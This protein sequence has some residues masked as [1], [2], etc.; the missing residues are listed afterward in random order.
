MEGSGSGSSGSSS[1]SSN[2][3]SRIVVD[4]D[5]TTGGSEYDYE[6]TVTKRNS[7]SALTLSEALD[8][9][10]DY[11]D[12]E[13]LT[14]VERDIVSGSYV[15]TVEDSYGFHYTYVYTFNASAN[16]VTIYV[17]GDAVDVA[18]GTTLGDLAEEC[19]KWM[20]VDGEYEDISDS[21]VEVTRGTRYTI[22]SKV[23]LDVGTDGNGTELYGEVG[24]AVDMTE[25]AGN[26]YKLDGEE[27]YLSVEDDAITFTAADQTV[28]DGYVY[29]KVYFNTG[30]PDTDSTTYVKAGT[31]YSTASGTGTGYIYSVGD[32]DFAYVANDGSI[33]ASDDVVI[34]KG[35]VAVT[36]TQTSGES[37][38]YSW[39]INSSDGYALA[40]DTLTVEYTISGLRNGDTVTVTFSDGSTDSFTATTTSMTMA[41][42]IPTGTDNISLSITGVSK[43]DYSGI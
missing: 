22:H 21:T 34:R 12:D 11:F 36:Y 42:D 26:Y 18:D 10:V 28:D 23:T 9:I 1:G 24:E 3:S 7:S 19:G 31:S 30:D 20:L 2:T 15:Y 8:A 16:E 27:D 25:L 13:N 17:N 4:A 43:V 37:N 41:V 38:S 32:S 39:T 14:V 29:I 5:A 35:Y 33:V 6:L 40:N